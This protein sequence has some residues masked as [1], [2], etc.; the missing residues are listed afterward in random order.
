[1]DSSVAWFVVLLVVAIVIVAILCCLE[2]IGR[3]FFFAKELSVEALLGSESLTHVTFSTIQDLGRDSVLCHK[4]SMHAVTMELIFNELHRASLDGKNCFIVLSMI[5]A[6][7]F[8]FL[9]ASGGSGAGFFDVMSFFLGGGEMITISI[10]AIK[11]LVMK[12]VARESLNHFKN[13]P[14]YKA[15]LV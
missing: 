1:M 12:S 13:E 6:L 9:R 5:G 8:L 4:I 10:V 7:V 11:V 3:R 2:L 15:L 14:V